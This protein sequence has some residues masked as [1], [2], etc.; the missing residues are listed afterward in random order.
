MYMYKF[1]TIKQSTTTLM[2]HFFHIPSKTVR[3]LDRATLLESQVSK[4]KKKILKYI[5]VR[6]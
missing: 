6:T 5:F 2:P 4:S 3:S 1:A